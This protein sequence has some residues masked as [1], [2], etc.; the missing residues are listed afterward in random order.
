MARKFT[1]EELIRGLDNIMIDLENRIE[2]LDFKIM[3]SDARANST[4]QYL[5]LIDIAAAVQEMVKDTFQDD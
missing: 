3:D 4:K 5:H 1:P 2:Q